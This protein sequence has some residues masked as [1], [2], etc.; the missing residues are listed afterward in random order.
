MRGAGRRQFL[1]MKWIFRAALAAVL[2]LLA[3]SVW[4]GGRR[5]CP[6]F[7]ANAAVAQQDLRTLAACQANFA[8]DHEGRFATSLEDLVSTGSGGTGYLAGR[9]SVPRDPWRHP[10]LL[11]V[12]AEESWFL[13]GSLGRDGR[14]GGEGD[15]ADLWLDSRETR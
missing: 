8:R 7:D 11:A 6:G 10:Y 12:A 4:V 9:T 15:D 3:F 1:V 2:G 5:S 13:V 14:L